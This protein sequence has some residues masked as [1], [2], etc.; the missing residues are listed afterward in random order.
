MTC[1]KLLQILI[2]VLFSWN[3][4]AEPIA[5][6]PDHP[7][8]YVVV[9]G[10]TLWDISAKFLRDPWLWPEVWHANPQISNPHLIYPGDVI[11]LVYVNGKLQLRLHRGGLPPDDGLPVVKLSPKVHVET[12]ERAITT[13]PLDAVQQ[14]LNQSGVVGPDEL[15]KLPYIVSS[16]G[17]H[18][19]TGAGD[20]VYVRAITDPQYS[21]YQV[22]RTGQA[23]IDP[24]TRE[25]LGHES[26]YIGDGSVQ[27]HGDPATVLLTR[28]TREAGIGDRLKPVAD[29]PQAVHFL[30]RGPDGPVDARIIAV[31]DGVTQIGQYQVVVIN[32]GQREGM[33]PGHVLGIYKWGEA[34][35]DLVTPDP[36]DTVK[37]P[38]ERAGVLMVF[39]T[40]EKVSYALVMK[41]VLPIHLLD[42][43]RNP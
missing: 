5:L 2:L 13:I 40:F 8:H 25:N 16:A 39:R 42:A 23:Y 1:K 14:F 29:E 19:I 26:L 30:P 31:M 32:R 33:M 15:S 9:K 3:A 36:K 41:A 43:V 37:L 21:R 12:L 22:L 27:R 28:T 20:R 38:D 35:R 10:D 18:L 24:I 6:N 11:S 34:V 7:E 17:E 4:L